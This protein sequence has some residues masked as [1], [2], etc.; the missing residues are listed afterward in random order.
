MSASQS[1][2]E[3][4]VTAFQKSETIMELYYWD[5][6][7][8]NIGDKAFKCKI[9]SEDDIKIFSEIV[10][11]SNPVHVDREYARNTVFHEPIA[12][13]MLIGS[14]IS[15]VLGTQLPGP[16]C[17]YLSQDFRFLK[18]VRVNDAITA[19]VE[20]VEIKT[21]NKSSAIVTLKTWCVNQHGDTVVNGEAV[22]KVYEEQQQ[23]IF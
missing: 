15:G 18:V 5:V 8:I 13:G 10:G 17:I 21:K 4:R 6:K 20:V 11:D 14:L 12:Q 2:M 3:E 1:L 22:M 16:G 7:K 9:I 19:F 23:S